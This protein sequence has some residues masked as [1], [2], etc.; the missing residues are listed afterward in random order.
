MPA[1]GSLA[2]SPNT[3]SLPLLLM[4]MKLVCMCVTLC[5]LGLAGR[6]DSPEHGEWCLS[7]SQDFFTAKSLTVTL[8]GQ[9]RTS[10]AQFSVA[11]QQQLPVRTEPPDNYLLFSVPAAMLKGHKQISGKQSALTISKE[12]GPNVCP[13]QT[14]AGNRACLLLQAAVIML[15][16]HDQNEIDN[17]PAHVQPVLQTCSYCA[18][19]M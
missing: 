13:V 14:S 15:S 11:A 17:L 5:L 8:Q 6:Q 16:S 3:G 7:P 4:I 1:S 2:P 12:A 19:N 10:T 9:L 18:V